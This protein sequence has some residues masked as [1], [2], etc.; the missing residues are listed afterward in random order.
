LVTSVSA[1]EGDV[2]ADSIVT[3]A[4]SLRLRADRNGA[5]TRREYWLTVACAD[6]AGDASQTVVTVRVPH[7]MVP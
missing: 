7:D 3:G 1:N 6:A 4:L 2:T 5:G